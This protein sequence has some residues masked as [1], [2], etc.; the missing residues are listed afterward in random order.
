MTVLRL[1]ELI[2]GDVSISPAFDQLTSTDESRKGGS[3]LAALAARRP[4]RSAVGGRSQAAVIPPIPTRACPRTWLS[5]ARWSAPVAP[6]D[7]VIA[8][9]GHVT[10]SPVRC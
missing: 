3:I 7:T 6:S 10:G 2:A 9:L 5:W 4:D 8:A 1:A